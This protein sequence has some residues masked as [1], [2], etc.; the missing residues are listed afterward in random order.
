ME[1]ISLA[2]SQPNLVNSEEV[3]GTTGYLTL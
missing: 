2:D 1:L 3:F